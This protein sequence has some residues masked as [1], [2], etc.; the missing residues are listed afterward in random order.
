MAGY[1]FGCGRFIYKINLLL[2][3]YLP[4]NSGTEVFESVDDDEERVINIVIDEKMSKVEVANMILK[5]VRKYCK[6]NNEEE[7]NRHL[8]SIP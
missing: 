7:M 2:K 4:Q 8:Q 5:A 3:C 6:E 1:R